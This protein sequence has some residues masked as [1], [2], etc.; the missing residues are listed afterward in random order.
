MFLY[1]THDGGTTW[2][3]APAPAGAA[4]VEVVD[5]GYE[6]ALVTDGRLMASSDD[7]R[8]W[9]LIGQHRELAGATIHP[10]Y[11]DRNHAFFLVT[12]VAAAG[13][14]DLYSTDDGGKTLT[15]P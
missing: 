14:V 10:Q 13:H 9:T 1:A 4:D 11:L 5:A 15:R 7:G 3:F 2:T 12:S 6:V 8:H